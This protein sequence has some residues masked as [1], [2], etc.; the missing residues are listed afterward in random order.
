METKPS[1][2]KLKKKLKSVFS[3]VIR[4]VGRCQ[5]C[6][7]TKMLECSHIRSKKVHPYLEFVTDNALCLCH[8]CH[9]YWFHKEPLEAADW[10]RE[11]FPDQ[12]LKLEALMLQEARGELRKGSIEKYQELLDH[13]N[14]ILLE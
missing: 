2:S 11:T 3:K 13:Y 6:G 12:I 10:V 5:R 8:R 14:K 7:S 9:I 1:K 4:K